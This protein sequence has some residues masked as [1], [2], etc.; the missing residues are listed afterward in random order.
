MGQAPNHHQH[1]HRLAHMPRTHERP[2]LHGPFLEEM[3]HEQI[4]AVPGRR[5]DDADAKS[6]W[7]VAPS[8]REDGHINQCLQH[9]QKSELWNQKSR[10][11]QREDEEPN[12]N[13]NR[14]ACPARTTYRI[15]SHVAFYGEPAEKFQRSS[16]VIGQTGGMG[17]GT[18]TQCFEAVGAWTCLQDQVKL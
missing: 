3:S 4:E 7:T 2:K 15:W 6:P 8:Q 12:S 9:V 5:D 17:A 10:T 1:R 13:R 11:R 14:H 18:T 16:K